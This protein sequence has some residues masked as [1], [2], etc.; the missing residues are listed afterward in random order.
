MYLSLPDTAYFQRF[1]SLLCSTYLSTPFP[2]PGIHLFFFSGSM[3]LPDLGYVKVGVIQNV[4]FSDW[5]L[6]CNNKHL[7]FLH[8]F[9]QLKSLFLFSAE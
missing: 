4:I 2:M 6:S 7:N 9:V 5:H 3:V 8:V 1:K